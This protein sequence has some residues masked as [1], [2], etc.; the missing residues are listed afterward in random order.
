VPAR[1][2][3]LVR[4]VTPKGF[5][6]QEKGRGLDSPAPS[7]SCLAIAGYLISVVPPPIVP[8]RVVV[9]LAEYYPR[10]SPSPNP[11]NRGSDATTRR[12]SH[13]YLTSRRCRARPWREVVLAA[14]TTKV[15][16][17]TRIDPP[18]LMETTSFLRRP[19]AARTFV[20]N[21]TKSRR[22][23]SRNLLEEVSY[24]T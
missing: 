3:S 6:R 19:S 17:T 24:R 7:P 1:S 16:S 18:R 12:P 11:T 13:K 2:N 5:V 4:L 21:E 14:F 23:L 22:S 10:S 8:S 9:G 20:V 15:A